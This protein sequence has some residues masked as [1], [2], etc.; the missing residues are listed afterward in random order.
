MIQEESGGIVLEFAG[1]WR[2]FAAFVID[3]AAL[4]IVFQ[5]VCRFS[6]LDT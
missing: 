6:I 5:F 4:S 2:R 1:F 3:A